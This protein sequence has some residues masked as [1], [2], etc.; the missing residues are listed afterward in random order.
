MHKT[1]APTTSSSSSEGRP[2]DMTDSKRIP[3]LRLVAITD[4]EALGMGGIVSVARLAVEAGLP[5]LMFREKDLPDEQALALLQELRAIT[6]AYGT[7]LIVNRRIGLARAVGA[8]GVHL[9]VDGPTIGEARAAL[10]PRALIGYSSHE[11]NEAMRA[12]ESGA[13]YVTFSPIF[14]TPS[15]TGFLRPV[16]LDALARLAAIAP[17]PVIALGG[18]D[19]SNIAEVAATGAAGV[20]VIRSVFGSSNPGESV[21]SLL[22]LWSRTHV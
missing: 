4:R 2:Q 3:D 10:G 15:K 18:I 11:P 19:A 13:D 22:R 21:R 12:F 16:G 7:T 20:A 14:E 9:G 17:G 5:A 6:A 8:D 1:L